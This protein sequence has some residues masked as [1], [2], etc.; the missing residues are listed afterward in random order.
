[1]S[2]GIVGL[3]RG[4]YM[5]EWAERVGLE[6]GAICDR[7]VEQVA[8]A[9]VKFPSARVSG[10]WVELLDA[11]LDGVIIANDFDGHAELAIAFLDRGVH[12]L[13]ETAACASEE[14]GRELIAAAERSTATY[15]FAENYVFHPHTR[16]LRESVDSGELGALAM[17][18]ADY[19]HSL[20]PQDTA[21]LI[22]DPAHWRGRIAPTAY[23]T[24]TVSPLLN[25]TGAWPVQVSAFAVGPGDDRPAAVAMAIRLSDGTL[26]LARHGFLAG[27]VDSHWSWI[28]VRGADGLAESGRATGDSAWSVRVRKEGWAQ[29]D[30]QTREEVR[31]P[32]P[33]LVHDEPIDPMAEGTVAVLEGF[34]ATIENGAPPLIP[35]RPAVAASLVGVAGAESLAQGSAPVPV[36][37]VSA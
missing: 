27:E 35:V 33:Y 5:G 23:C 10:D 34:R 4:M 13:S 19:L 15:S 21:G 14:E 17:V 6:V 20:S 37:D 9:R 22:G 31:A 36:P 18:E 28:S 12:V 26:A 2:I 30:G 25:L 24:H 7:D 1:M 16:L 29:P 3:V 32:H 8:A 11:G